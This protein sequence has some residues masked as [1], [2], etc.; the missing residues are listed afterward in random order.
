MNEQQLELF[1]RLAQQ[2]DQRIT[3]GVEPDMQ[4]QIDAYQAQQDA[5]NAAIAK[6]VI[7]SGSIH[8]NETAPGAPVQVG[9]KPTGV[10]TL[11]AFLKQKQATEAAAKANPVTR[12]A[13]AIAMQAQQAQQ[14]QPSSELTGEQPSME[15]FL[16]MKQQGL[17]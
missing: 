3:R 2:Q 4:A 12:Q 17:I 16:A 14:A 13:M 8:S 15:E 11:E 10:D 9:S 7:N 1:Q 5:E 6:Q